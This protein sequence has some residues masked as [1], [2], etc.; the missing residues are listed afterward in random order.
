MNF[1]IREA[2]S[3]DYNAICKLTIEVHNLHVINRPDV[4]ADVNNPL[5]KE[6]FIGLINTKNTKVFVVENID[7]RELVA[8]SIVRIMETQ[9]IPILIQ[10]RFAFLDEFC[11]KSN[12]KKNGIGRL[13]FQYIVDYAKAEG[14][15]SLQLGVWEFNE[16]A[17]DFYKKMGMST[18]NRKMELSLNES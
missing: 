6:H 16:D 11:V 15:S 2:I 14:A 8:Y 17:F 4:F 9:S 18:R 13:L 7:N 12:Y 5:L 10:K 3:N 1:K